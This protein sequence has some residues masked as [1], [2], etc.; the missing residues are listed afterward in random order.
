MEFSDSH[1]NDFGVYTSAIKL[2]GTTIADSTKSSAYVPVANSKNTAYKRF[3]F[4]G[5]RVNAGDVFSYTQTNQN[6]K[7]N[8]CALVEAI[9]IPDGITKQ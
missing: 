9:I 2:N 8:P 4:S 6:G 1:T 3:V 5:L 7:N